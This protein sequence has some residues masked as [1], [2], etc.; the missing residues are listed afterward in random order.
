MYI[1]NSTNSAQLRLS[2]ACLSWVEI[3]LSLYYGWGG[4]NLIFFLSISSSWVNLWLHTENQL[5]MLLVSAL[6]VC[7]VV[8][9]WVVGIENEFSDRLWLEQLNYMRF[10]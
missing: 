5:F 2:S 7:V 8:G 4:H 6:K 10:F 1:I 9:G 3:I